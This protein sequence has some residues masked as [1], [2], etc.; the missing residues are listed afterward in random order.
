VSRAPKRCKTCP[1]R[2]A[3][4]D[5]KRS[6]AHIAPDDWPCHTEDLRGDTSIECRGHY[7]AQRRFG[8]LIGPQIDFSA[9]KEWQ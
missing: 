4:D 7:E 1:F 8:V 3:G 6:C 9:P 2:G 5:Y